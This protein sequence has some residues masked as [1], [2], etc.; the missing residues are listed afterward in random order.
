MEVIETRFIYNKQI[1]RLKKD[2]GKIQYCKKLAVN[3][4]DFIPKVPL[5]GNCNGL[6]RLKN[7][8]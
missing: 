7:N 6:M 1:I 3:P 4:I 2:I 5:D 8:D